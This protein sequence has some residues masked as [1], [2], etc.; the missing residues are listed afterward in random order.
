MYYSR[1]NHRIFSLRHNYPAAGTE[2]GSA[3]L[4]M[5]VSCRAVNGKADQVMLVNTPKGVMLKSLDRVLYAFVA[6]TVRCCYS[7]KG[8][9]IGGIIPSTIAG[10][11]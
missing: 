5:G 4:A 2:T 6:V 7:G 8:K 3:M 9:R 1:Y 10:F 11:M